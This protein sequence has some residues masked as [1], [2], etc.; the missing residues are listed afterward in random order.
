MEEATWQ[1]VV[2]ISKGGRNYSGIGL[3]EVVWK[4]IAVIL[5]FCF[6]DS[7][8]YHKSLHE[9]RAGS[10]TGTLEL[11]I[12]QQVTSMREEVLHVIFL[13]LH[14]AYNTLDRSRCLEILEV[15][16]VGTRALRLFRR[17]CERLQMVAWE[18]GYYGEPLCG[19]IGIMQGNPLLPTIFNVVVEILVC[20]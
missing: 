16:V 1:A 5:N 14:K 18:G 3:V 8:S 15:Y 9:F 7:I 10:G 2:L 19:E 12:L 13:Y 11:K 4:A 20:P 6:T 17:Y